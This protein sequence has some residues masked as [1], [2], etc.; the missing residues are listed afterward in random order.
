MKHVYPIIHLFKVYLFQSQCISIDPYLSTDIRSSQPYQF[1]SI[2]P[3]TFIRSHPSIH[4]YPYP[5][6]HPSIH[7]LMRPSI[8]APIYPCT[9]S[10]IHHSS[11]YPSTINPSMY[12][13]HKSLLIITY[14]TILPFIYT[15]KSLLINKY[16]F[17]HPPIPINRD[18][19]IRVNPPIPIHQYLHIHPSNHPCLCLS[20]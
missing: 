4:I 16:T 20:G 18:S 14:T 11:I 19:S 15:R 8:H 13:Y 12:L 5:S 10:P 2:H 1:I 7:P 9:L 3:Y 6:I 17:I